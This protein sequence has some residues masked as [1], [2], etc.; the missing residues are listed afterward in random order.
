[1]TLRITTPPDDPTLRYVEDS[2]TKA[3]AGTSVRVWRAPPGLNAE[4]NPVDDPKAVV[5][6]I[7]F[8]E[9]VSVE[10]R[11]IAVTVGEVALPAPTEQEIA[12]ALN[13]LKS[14]DGNR[15]KAGADRLAKMYVVV[16]DRR[17]EVAKALEAAALEKDFWLQQPAL[18]ALNLWAGPE[19]AA[20]LIRVLEAVDWPTRNIVCPILGRLKDPAAAPALAKLLPGLGDRGP[21][22]AALKAIGPGA[23]KAVIPFLTHKDSW[24]SSEACHILKEIGT[25]ASVAPLQEILKGKPDFMVGPAAANAL[26][27]I[28][29]R[30]KKDPK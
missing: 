15:R 3:F 29:E 4:I 23:E 6:K 27:A 17:V 7:T 16:P 8:G 2:V 26:K 18:R 20:G 30:K 21:A 1:M 12:L 22:S 19:N 5:G 11:T 24:A 25:E 28:Q 14:T 10:G 13:D 9:V